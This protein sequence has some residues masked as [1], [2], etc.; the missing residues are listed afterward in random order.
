MSTK[1]VKKNNIKTSSKTIKKESNKKPIEAKNDLPKWD[2]SDLY[3]SIKDSAIKSDIKTIAEL[4]KLFNKNYYKKVNKL[5][6]LELFYAIS[7]YEN[8]C[9]KIAKISTF[10]YLVYAS[11][12]SNSDNVSFFQ[13]SSETLSKFESELVFFI[14]EINLIDEKQLKKLLEDNQKTA[15]KNNKISSKNSIKNTTK[16]SLKD[17]QPFLRDCRTF[18]NYQLSHELEK[19]N[20]EKSVTSRSAFVRLFDET[21]NNLQ[22]SFDKKILNSQQIFNLLCNNEEHTRRKAADSISKVFTDNI[23]TFAFITNILA[24]DKAI[25]D[26]YRGYKQPIS[27]RN[28][29]NFVEDSVVELLIKKVKEN[30]GATA[31]RYYKIKAKL[32]GKKFLNYYDRNAP[33]AKKEEKLIDWQEAKQMVLEAYE[34]FHPQFRKIGEQFFDKNWIDAKVATGKD[35]GAFSHPC[36]PSVHPFILMNFQGKVRDV[37]TLAHE[38]GHG[39]HQFL[40]AKQGFL[41][42]QTPLTLAETASVFGEQ[43]VFQKILAAEKNPQQKK[44]IIANKVEDMIN[45]V[46]R[47]IAFLDFELK[48]HEERKKG[49]ISVEQLGKFWLEIQQESLGSAF[50][51]SEDYRNFWCYIPHFIHS[52]FYVYSYAFG[53]CLVNSLYGILKS[54]DSSKKRQE[55]SEKYLE[56][57]AAGGIKHHKELLQ[58]FGISIAKPEFW[59]FGLDVLIE[60]IDELEELA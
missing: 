57:L 20:L 36:V 17:Y 33:I 2:L 16:N 42:S 4:V 8:I 14:L 6:S 50:K 40:A 32:L 21:I 37:M 10:S 59:Q 52:P 60:L 53:D 22:F 43:L 46:V 49:E 44:L 35:S 45:T 48:V 29:S 34:E 23:K 56:M 31:H 12:L 54:Q 9:E 38:L 39:I 41:Q 1:I 7:E 47:Q 27:S 19:F 25:E 5:N 3:S 30:Y 58:P 24:K 51:F 26:S 13:N 11:D 28:L 15:T 18:K 55:F